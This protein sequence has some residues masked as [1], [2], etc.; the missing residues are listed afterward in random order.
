MD[1][2]PHNN[3][4]NS[5]ENEDFK[6]ISNIFTISLSM[7]LFEK[8]LLEAINININNIDDDDNKMLL[9]NCYLINKKFLSKFKIFFSYDEIEKFKI[10][11]NDEDFDIEQS[12]KEEKNKEFFDSIYFPNFLF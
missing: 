7:N 3:Y 1:K 4:I 2:I 10:L 9:E 8:E 6:F 11:I 5:K 12:I